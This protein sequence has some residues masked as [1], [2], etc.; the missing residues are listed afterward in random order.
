MRREFEDHA[1]EAVRDIGL[2]LA[3]TDQQQVARTDASEWPQC[4]MGLAGRRSTTDVGEQ[5][6]GALDTAR[7]RARWL[8]ARTRIVS[9]K[10]GSQPLSATANS[11]SK[12]AATLRHCETG[13]QV[14]V[15]AL[16]Q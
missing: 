13:Q 1:L 5:V 9:P 3:G 6:M 16:I 2:V 10:R 12:S 14:S 8:R 15:T 7:R 4:W 11:T